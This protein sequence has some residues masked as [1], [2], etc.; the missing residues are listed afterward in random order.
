M[1]WYLDVLKKYAVF[2]GRARRKEFWM[3]VLFNFVAGVVLSI[4]DRTL[5]ST[6]G[7]QQT[8]ILSSIYS[9]AIF[10]PSLAVGIR[11]MHDIGKN[12]TWILINL[13]PFVGWIWY[14]VLAAKE[15]QA[16][17]N[18]FGPDPKASEPPVIAA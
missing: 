10:I 17:P 4:L 16:G 7:Q 14:I 9:L 11:R 2:S 8:G 1:N 18:Q 12:G 5:G 6:Y 15:G 13:I 3:F